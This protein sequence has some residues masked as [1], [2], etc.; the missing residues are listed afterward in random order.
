MSKSSYSKSQNSKSNKPY[1]ASI[2]KDKAALTAKIMTLIENGREE[3][4]TKE[5]LQEFP[6]GSV[7][8]YMNKAGIFKPAGFI[9]RFD[10]D[11]FVYI[12]P[13]FEKCIRVKYKQVK[14]IWVGNVYVTRNDI[15]SIVPSDNKK[16]KFVAMV[17]DVPVYYGRDNASL[18]RFLCTN[19]Y[20]KMQQWYDIFGDID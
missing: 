3:I 1:I 13:D 5:Q 17:G 12:T 8:S 10:D 11:Y 19:K 18:K 7:I 20:K 15:V 16:T 9:K 6:I 4:T 2:N 14:K